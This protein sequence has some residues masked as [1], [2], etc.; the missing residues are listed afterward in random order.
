MKLFILIL[1]TTFLLNPCVAQTISDNYSSGIASHFQ[2]YAVNGNFDKLIIAS[3]GEAGLPA[4]IKTIPV[5]QE[6]AQWFAEAIMDNQI[7]WG[8]EKDFSTTTAYAMPVQ[9][10]VI[11]IAQGQAQFLL[12][13]IREAQ[14]AFGVENDYSGLKIRAVVGGYDIPNNNGF[15]DFNG[16]KEVAN[17]TLPDTV[18]GN[19]HIK[20]MMYVGPGNGGGGVLYQAGFKGLQES[21]LEGQSQQAVEFVTYGHKL[22]GIEV[23][24]YNSKLIYWEAMTPNNDYVEKVWETMYEASNATLPQVKAI[25]TGMEKV[26]FKS[27]NFSHYETAHLVG[28]NTWSH[29]GANVEAI[30]QEIIDTNKPGSID[31]FYETNDQSLNGIMYVVG[32]G[33][34]GGGAYIMHRK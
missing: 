13:S 28:N 9:M 21:M 34:G 19:L 32:P 17:N 29:Y 10:K 23:D 4:Q 30:I 25:Q 27:S 12:Q 11:P 3:L 26:T 8:V 15:S 33:N 20:S 5:T 6:Q 7:A 31:G 1:L 14:T 16:A 2:K 18:K 24:P 22:Q